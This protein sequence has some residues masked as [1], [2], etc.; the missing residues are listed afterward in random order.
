MKKIVFIFWLLAAVVV[1]SCGNGLRTGHAMSNSTSVIS[2][3]ASSHKS[4]L[5]DYELVYWDSVDTKKYKKPENPPSTMATAAPQLGVQAAAQQTESPASSNLHNAYKL[6]LAFSSNDNQYVDDRV[7]LVSSVVPS[8]LEDSDSASVQKSNPERFFSNCLSEVE[9]SGQFGEAAVM[10]A[11][12]YFGHLANAIERID[13]STQLPQ[14]E[15]IAQ[16]V[17]NMDAL[18]RYFN[19][20]LRAVEDVNTSIVIQAIQERASQIDEFFNN[21]PESESEGKY[22]QM[23]DKIRDIESVFE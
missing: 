20:S 17:K 8:V 16:G 6:G 10:V 2:R 5:R 7:S 22:D 9:E 3:G 12:F 13:P 1:S 4:V 15:V 14:M 11:G 18:N 23:L 21:A 19:E